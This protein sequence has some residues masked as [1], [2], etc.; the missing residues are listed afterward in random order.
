MSAEARD[1]VG[2]QQAHL[3]AGEVELVIQALRDLEPPPE[4]AETVRKDIEY[5]NTN[6]ERMK[7]NDYRDRGMH[8]GSGIV[9]S[10]CKH[11]AN[12]RLKRSGCRWTQRG[13]QATLNLRILDLNGRWDPYW[14]RQRHVA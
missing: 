8:I 1:W 7:Y 12:E 11:V 2:Q 9:E 3:R 5:F 14:N 13:A 6:R 10:A 4:A